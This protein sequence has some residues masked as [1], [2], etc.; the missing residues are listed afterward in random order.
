MVRLK[1]N[2][3][4]FS[5]IMICC[6]AGM[7][8]AYSLGF[9]VKTSL[10]NISSIINAVLLAILVVAGIQQIYV[11]FGLVFS[12]IRRLVWSGVGFTFFITAF[13]I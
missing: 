5:I 10:P 6:Q 7:T 13:C 11:G 2:T 3:F 1:K 9:S 12:Y 8:V 4:A